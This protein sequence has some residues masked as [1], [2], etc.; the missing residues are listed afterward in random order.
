MVDIFM[1]LLITGAGD[2]LQGIKRGIMELADIL[3]VTKD[4][5]DNR[6]RAAAHCQ[7]L[8]MVLHYLQSPTPGWT[9]SVLT[10]PSLEG[11]GLDTIEETLFRF[12]DSMKESGFWY[13]RRRSQSLSWVQSLVHEALLTAFEQH[14]AVA[15]RMPILENMVAGDKM[16]PVSAAHDLLSHF[17]YP[18]PGH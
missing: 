15:S 3:V 8:K 1:L 18:A 14:P 11:R 9:P 4:D 16:D 12:R 17:T 6:Q 7:E 10:C 13:S 5:G 2:D